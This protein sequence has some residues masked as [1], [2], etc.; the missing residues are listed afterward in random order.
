MVLLASTAS[1]KQISSREAEKIASEF[2]SA[3]NLSTDSKVKIL[4]LNHETAESDHQGFYV[5]STGND[6]GFVLVSGDDDFGPIIGYADSCS[7]DASRI[8][9]QLEKLLNDYEINARS[10]RES[11]F[12]KRNTL[13]GVA[14]EP[15][16][17]TKWGQDAPYNYYCRSDKWST[18]YWATG[19]VA[20]AM[21]QVMKYYEYPAGGKGKPLYTE[22][23]YDL[24][25]YTYDWENMRETYIPE[26]YTVQE[27]EAVGRLM[28]D[29]GEAVRT[30]YGSSSSSSYGF[31]TTPAMYRNF[32]YSSDITRLMRSSYSDQQWIDIIRENLKLG[33]PI[34][35]SASGNGGHSFICDG[36]DTDDFLHINWGW[37]GYC[38]G[39]YDMQAFIPAGTPNNGYSYE[40]E[41]IVNIRP[42]DPETDNTQYRNRLYLYDMKVINYFDPTGAIIPDNNPMTFGLIFTVE[43]TLWGSL[44]Y[45]GWRGS[46]YD[47]NKQLLI[48]EFNISGKQNYLDINKYYTDCSAGVDF[49]GV[50]DGDYFIS[51]YYVLWE[52]TVN[53]VLVYGDPQEFD[54]GCDPYIAV[55][56]KDGV[57]YIPQDPV[58][59]QSVT[60]TMAEQRHPIYDADGGPLTFTIT[61]NNSSGCINPTIAIY[62]LPENSE[63]ENP[64]ISEMKSIGEVNGGV[65][66]GGA[67][68][69]SI[70][71]INC[72]YNNLSP[73]RYRLYFYYNY[74]WLPT[75]EKYYMQVTEAPEDVP[76]TLTGYIAP[77]FKTYG[78][79]TYR[80]KISAYYISTPGWEW[81]FG[82][83]ME[84]RMVAS[85]REDFADAQELFVDTDHWLRY[86]NYCK[87]IDFYGYPIMDNWASG[88]YYVKMQFRKDGDTEWTDAV[89]CN[90]G[91]F[92]LIG[93]DESGLKSVSSESADAPEEIFSLGGIKINADKDN[94]PV[95][96]YLIRQGSIVN[97]IIVR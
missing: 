3:R 7:F 50:E 43:N 17:K 96:I 72:R 71:N 12:G 63:E 8:P 92:T 28:R 68:R 1:A 58:P 27:A 81:W 94:L 19:C 78:P 44:R 46:L 15:L 51:L 75:D 47:S 30:Y 13:G 67:S 38:D 79:Y 24:S 66:Y 21:A 35:Y 88:K 2:Y 25:Q 33:E 20:T 62:C 42:G 85:Q 57:L 82:G 55:S 61:N 60:I 36:I 84:I 10:Q 97:K 11:S 56:I 89:G 37:A 31:F 39:Y 52:D 6:K 34:I 95:G 86:Y 9:P 80:M 65:L 54:F 4:K 59:D 16:I 29:C 70:A 45:T 87:G 18:D 14:V 53:N 83:P 22:N 49:T 32:N 26:Q 77:E 23:A 41:M 5:F 40:H 64:E 93:E 48:K 76:F 74:S 91:T 69:E 73:G 90:Y